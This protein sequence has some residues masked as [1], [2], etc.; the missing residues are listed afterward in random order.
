MISQTNCRKRKRY[1]TFWASHNPI[2]PKRS[3]RRHLKVN[4]SHILPHDQCSSRLP[5]QRECFSSPEQN[6]NHLHEMYADD[7]SVSSMESEINSCTS[8]SD[9]IEH[10]EIFSSFPEES[11]GTDGEFEHPDEIVCSTSSNDF[12]TNEV[13][14]E[15]QPDDLLSVNES[16]SAVKDQDPPVY[17][18]C[19]LRLSESVLLIMTLAIRHKLTGDALSD[20]I[21]LID[22]HCIPG[23]NS[24]S[25]KTLRELKS[26]FA[27]SK[28]ALNQ[29]FYCNYCFCLLPTEH[30]SVC[31]I[32]ATDLDAI[33]TAK[34][35]FVVLPIKQQ[36]SRFLSR[37]YKICIIFTYSKIVLNNP[38]SYNNFSVSLSQEKIL[39]FQVG[40][41]LENNK[42]N[43]P[44]LE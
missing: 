36:L 44:I 19:P 38:K 2:P 5:D 20:V 32:C 31:P 17:P 7:E 34:R 28:E 37:E 13:H 24:H 22:L 43:I 10:G 30:T 4:S 12:E 9:E 42:I 25:I 18:S 16:E 14:N 23:P 3:L 15:M 27:D 6:D 8:E 11:E 41:L 39:K 29:L 33:S 35:Y 1:N 40:L 26:F 21:K